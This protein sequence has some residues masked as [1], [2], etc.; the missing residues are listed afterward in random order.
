[1][2]GTQIFKMEWFKYIWDK[3]YI[4]ST[5]I[6]AIINIFV[7]IYFTHIIDNYFFGFM[8]VFFSVNH[9]CQYDFYVSLSFSFG[10]NGL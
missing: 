4:I 7:T 9:F 8:V 3:N 6:L 1:M 2:T 10:V 5:S